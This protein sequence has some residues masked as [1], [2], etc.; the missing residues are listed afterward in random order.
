MNHPLWVEGVSDALG[1]VAGALLGYGLA[2]LLGL[3]PLTEHYDLPSVAGIAL[4]GLGG[5][6]GLNMARRWRLKRNTP[7][8]TQR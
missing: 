2:M 7:D 8:K 5:G 1:F 3:N 4:V 6:A